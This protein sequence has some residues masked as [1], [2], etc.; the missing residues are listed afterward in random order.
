MN[1][2]EASSREPRWAMAVRRSGLITAVVLAVYLGA[3]VVLRLGGYLV[4]W[5]TWFFCI[6]AGKTDLQCRKFVEATYRPMCLLEE[7]IR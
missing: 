2:D 7:W 3:Y 5:Q 4:Y 1:R 6:E